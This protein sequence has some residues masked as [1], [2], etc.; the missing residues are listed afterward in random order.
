MKPFKTSLWLEAWDLRT[1]PFWKG[2]PFDPQEV[3]L[4]TEG[5]TVASK[6]AL[7]DLPIR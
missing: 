3:E 2:F 4:F 6:G 1:L 7:Q 5:P